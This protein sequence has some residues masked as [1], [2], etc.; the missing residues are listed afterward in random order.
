VKITGIIKGIARDFVSGKYNITLEVNEGYLLQNEYDNLKE[1]LLSIELKKFQKKRSIDS[2]SYSWVLITA[3]AKELSKESPVTKDEIYIQMLK[4]YS[5]KCT[6]VIVPSYQAVESL[7]EI[8]REVEVMNEIDIN[9]R[10]GIQLRLYY[11]SSTFDTEEMTR[12]IDGIVTECKDLGIETL[13]PSELQIMNMKWRK[14]D[15]EY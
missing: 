2:N 1:K 6:Y 9:G 15:D 3:I 13:T 8:Y 7:K 14:K 12:F 5:N 4:K 10:V 11:G